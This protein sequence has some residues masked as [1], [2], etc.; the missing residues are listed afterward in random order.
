MTTV[1]EKIDLLVTE[2]KALQARQLKLLTTV[3]DFNTCMER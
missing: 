1:E 2:V 3:D